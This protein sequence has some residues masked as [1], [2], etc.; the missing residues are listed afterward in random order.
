MTKNN[1]TVDQFM[2]FIRDRRLVMRANQGF[3]EMAHIFRTLHC[4][5]RVHPISHES[6]VRI[7]IIDFPWKRSIGG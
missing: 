5:L 7:E 1:K 4:D 2:Q 3:V 6:T